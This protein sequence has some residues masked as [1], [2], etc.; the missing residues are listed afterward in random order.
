[1]AKDTKLYK[2]EIGRVDRKSGDCLNWMSKNVTAKDA[3]AAIRK[4][5]L[6]GSEYVVAVEFIAMVDV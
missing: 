4:I 5:K 1:M 6:F 3:P 2:I